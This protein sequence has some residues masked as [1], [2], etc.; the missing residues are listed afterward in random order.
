M[1]QRVNT[2]MRPISSPPRGERNVHVLEPVSKVTIRCAGKT[3]QNVIEVPEMGC[4]T[5][6]VRPTRSSVLTV[7]TTPT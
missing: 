4:G 3:W 7:T 2:Q 1:N 6:Q 5:S